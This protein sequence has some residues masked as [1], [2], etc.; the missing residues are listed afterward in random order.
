MT[1]QALMGYS[2]SFIPLALREV[3]SRVQYGYQDS[4]H[5]AVNS[6]I[7]IACN[8]TLSILLCRKFGVFGVTLASSVATLVIGMLNVQSAR[9]TR[10]IPVVEISLELNTEHID[11][12]NPVHP[13]DVGLQAMACRTAAADSAVLDHFLCVLWI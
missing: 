7:G 3:Y 4:K 9:R 12:W 2:L 11:R 5:P 8:V 6:V 1:A 13:F 10:I